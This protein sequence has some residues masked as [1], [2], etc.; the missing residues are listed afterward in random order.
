MNRNFGSLI[1]VT[2]FIT[3][4]FATMPHRIIFISGD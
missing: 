2:K 1:P 4:P 3:G